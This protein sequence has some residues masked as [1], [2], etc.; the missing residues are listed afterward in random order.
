MPSTPRNGEFLFTAS[1]LLGRG[2]QSG[3][4]CLVERRVRKYDIVHLIPCPALRDD[5][6]SQSHKMGYS[7][8]YGGDACHAPIDPCDAYAASSGSIRLRDWVCNELARGYVHNVSGGLQF[9]N[10]GA[11][12]HDF[13]VPV[14]A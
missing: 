4:K 9:C 1:S 2:K 13:D 11:C 8:S 7:M 14:D 10:S 3:F 5:E 6:R 12:P